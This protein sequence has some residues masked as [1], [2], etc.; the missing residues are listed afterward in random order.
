MLN[1]KG[2]RMLSQPKI[3]KKRLEILSL[4]PNTRA[5][6][7]PGFI[8]SRHAVMLVQGVRRHPKVYLNSLNRTCLLDWNKS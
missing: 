1:I 2:R 7:G 6:N 3:D 5:S 8:D 4:D